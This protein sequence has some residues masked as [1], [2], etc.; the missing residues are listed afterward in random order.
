MLAGNTKNVETKDQTD[1]VIGNYLRNRSIHKHF[2]SQNEIA[3]SMNAFP[4]VDF[5]YLIEQ[6]NSLSGLKE[7]HFDNQTTWG[8]QSEG[9][10]EAKQAIKDG[11]H[12]GFME[13]KDYVERHDNLSSPTWS[14][15]MAS[16]FQN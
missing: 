2:H 11:P 7:I 6:Q 16:L 13:L 4:K 8:I 5:R 10:E 3:M 14:S 9:R 1:K 12:A 15:F